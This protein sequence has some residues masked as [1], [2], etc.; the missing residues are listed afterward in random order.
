MTAQPLPQYARTLREPRCHPIDLRRHPPAVRLVVRVRQRLEKSRIGLISAR[1]IQQE[2]LRL[3]LLNP[4][5]SQTTI[6]RWLR[7]AGLIGAGTEPDTAA[8]YPALPPAA[9]FVTFSC[10]WV[11]RYLTGGEKVFVFHTID[12]QTHALA[13]TIRADKSTASTCEHLLTACAAL[14]LPDFLQ[15][16]NDAAFTGLSPH[17]ARVRAVRA[18]RFIPRPRTD[19]YSTRGTCAQPCR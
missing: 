3:R 10:D 8:Y 19:L 2:L 13:Q 17:H 11:A 1:A 18:H 12:L 15:L 16:D 4:P 7:Q 6:K 5:P 9:K 14:G